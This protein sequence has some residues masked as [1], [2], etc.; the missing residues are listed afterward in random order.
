MPSETTQVSKEGDHRQPKIE[1]KGFLLTCGSQ[2]AYFP[3]IPRARLKNKKFL[4]IILVT[5]NFVKLKKK[6][7]SI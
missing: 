7:A 2:Y 6:F 3:M 1:G 4:L 5:I